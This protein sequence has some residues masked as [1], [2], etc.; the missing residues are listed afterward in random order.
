MDGKAEK[1]PR[2]L[3]L[4]ILSAEQ[5]QKSEHAIMNFS[6]H[7]NGRRNVASW[8]II[9]DD[10][11]VHKS[12]DLLSLLTPMLPGATCSYQQCMHTHLTKH[13]LKLQKTWDCT[14]QC[15]QQ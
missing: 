1:G 15:M 13:H 7:E 2:Q 12:W 4:S 5:T 14:D 3:L 6:M 9:F 11:R 10:M 8:G